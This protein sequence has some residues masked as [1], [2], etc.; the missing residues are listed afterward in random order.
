VEDWTKCEEKFIYESYIHHIAAVHGKISSV[1]YEAAR[2]INGLT[3]DAVEPTEE[4]IK[5]WLTGRR[6][7][8]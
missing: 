3:F 6:D 5:G 1:L 8:L 2:Y 7:G 4:E